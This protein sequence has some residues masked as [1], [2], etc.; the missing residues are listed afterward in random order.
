MAARVAFAV[1]GVRSRS[2]TGIA[3]SFFVAGASMDDGEPVGVTPKEGGE[4][5]VCPT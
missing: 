1:S 2:L 5:E 4:V 3:P